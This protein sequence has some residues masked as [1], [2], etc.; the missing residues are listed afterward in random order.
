[1]ILRGGQLLIIA[2]LTGTFCAAPP[3]DDWKLDVVHLKSGGV[4]K[5]LVVKETSNS[6]VFWRVTRKPGA[7]TGVL[8]ATIERKEIDHID[9][10][11]AGEREALSAR[12][13]ALDPTGQGE[14]LRMASLTLATA[15]WG[16]EGKG[17]ARVYRSDHFV[18]ESN[19]AEDIVRRAAVRL[20]Y[21]YAAT[22]RFLPPRLE[23]AEPTRIYLARSLAD[24]QALLRE[25]GHTKLANPAFYDMANNQIF[26]GSELQRLG[27]SLEVIRKQHQQLLA[28][29]RDKEAELNKL[30]KGRVP[31]QLLLPIRQ[32]RHEVAQ[33][34]DKNE[35]LF[36]EATAR[37]FQRLYHEAFHAYL[38]TFVYAASETEVPRWLNEGLA[39]IFE[40]AIVEAGELRVGH[41]DRER[42]KRVQ[43]LAR[44]GRLI[45]LTDL[46]K[47]GPK[48]FLVHHATEKQNSDSYYL[49]S[50][51]LAF[52]LTFERRLLGGK[53]MDA[54]VASLHRGVDPLDAFAELVGQPLSE[55]DKE[56]RAYLARLSVA[57]SQGK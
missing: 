42:A 57:K 47:S 43:E 17:L 38:T 10:L 16:K 35:R 11:E 51:A 52:Y 9:A 41:P 2:L 21:L 37:L 12:L 53:A 14:V 32:S 27:D 33:Q 30:Y 5:G 54:Y 18:L 31:A 45:G 24:Y 46:L 4:L 48:Q 50:W 7:Y 8:V 15:D 49:S 25:H 56:F 40:T 28:E 34:D 6:V 26:C 1:M 39:Q 44:S 36:Q 3:D 55:F 13:K 23:A 22:T 19:A 20:E 29:L